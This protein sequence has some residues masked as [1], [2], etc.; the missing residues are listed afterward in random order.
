[1]CKLCDICHSMWVRSN[2]G[3]YIDLVVFKLYDL[4]NVEE[5]MRAYSFES[6]KMVPS[7]NK[8]Y[9]SSWSER[10]SD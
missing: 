2:Y 5:K 8:G 1:M 3:W 7:W 9:T 10:I 6:E 4:V